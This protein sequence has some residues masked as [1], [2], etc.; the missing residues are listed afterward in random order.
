MT[1][2]L[3]GGFSVRWRIQHT[4]AAFFSGGALRSFGAGEIFTGDA[5]RPLRR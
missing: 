5:V 2:R 3:A 1:A 4:G